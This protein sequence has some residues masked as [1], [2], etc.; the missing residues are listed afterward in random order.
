MSYTD[1]YKNELREAIRRRG[2][3]NYHLPREDLSLLGKC[4]PYFNAENQHVLYSIFSTY[5]SEPDG[6][7]NLFNLKGQCLMCHSKMEEVIK[8]E[9]GVQPFLTVG[10][11]TYRSQDMFKFN[12]ITD[13]TIRKTKENKPGI[14]NIHVWLT[15][16]SFEII[17]FTFIAHL[18]YVNAD[19]KKKRSFRKSPSFIFNFGNAE[20]INS[21]ACVVY[22]PLYLGKDILVKNGFIHSSN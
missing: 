8:K 12:S 19:D 2:G 13:E 7:F 5:F 18:V 17:D 11:V 20:Y 22:H 16:P 14:V 21:E 6:T 3:E 10:Y 15:L 9:L 4:Q 1:L